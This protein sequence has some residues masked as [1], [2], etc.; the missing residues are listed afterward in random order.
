MESKAVVAWLRLARAYQK[1][2]QA[3]TAQLR[4]FGL[5]LA[6]FDVLTQVGAAEG[7]TQQELAARLLVTKGNVSQLIDR[8][9][10]AGLVVRVP[11]G[12]ICRL[13]L[14]PSGRALSAR[15]VPAHEAFI[16]RAFSALSSEEQARLAQLLRTIDRSLD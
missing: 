11:Q 15:V 13:Y 9:E 2:A 4:E 14:T 6:Q 5:S 1:V 16:A 12:R 8:L 10:S 7:L 3:A